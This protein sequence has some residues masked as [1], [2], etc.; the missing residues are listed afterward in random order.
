MLIP[1]YAPIIRTG[2]RSQRPAGSG[3]WSNLCGWLIV[4]TGGKFLLGAGAS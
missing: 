2:P 3:R 1:A 4:T